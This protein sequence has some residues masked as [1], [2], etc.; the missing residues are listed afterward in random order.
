M[1]KHIQG[2]KRMLLLLLLL[3]RRRKGPNQ[4][5]P[6]IC[7]AALWIGSERICAVSECEGELLIT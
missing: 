1:A 4:H 5:T 6:G 3:K 7:F 2:P